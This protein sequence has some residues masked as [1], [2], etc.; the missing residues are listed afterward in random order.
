V[1]DLE[2]RDVDGARERVFHQR[3]RRELAGPSSTISSRKAF[4]MPW[5]MPPWI[6]P[7]I[8]QAGSAITVYGMPGEQKCQAMGLIQQENRA[9]ARPFAVP[10]RR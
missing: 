5:A 1:M 2:G 8:A 6:W 7:S 9:P 10:P 3:A 4:P